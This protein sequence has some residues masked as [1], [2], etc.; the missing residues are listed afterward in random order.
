MEKS[1]L[2]VSELT[3]GIKR[4]LEQ[5]YASV[6]V[7]GEV[8]RLTRHGS[9][10]I[11][12]TI[13]DANAA[14]SAVIWRS[15]AARLKTLPEEGREFVFSG[16]ISVY[17]P[18]GAYQLIVR[19]VAG[20]GAG[21]LAAEFERRKALFAERGWFDTARKKQP[22]P[23][24][25]HI[26]IVTSPSAAALEDVKKV[27][28]TRPGWLELTLS[29]CI[30]QGAQAAAAI[31]TAINRLS[32]LPEPPDVILLVRGGGSMEDLW[33]FNDETVVKAVVDCPVPIIS[34]IGHEIDITLADFAADVR[35][36]TP[37]N[38]A[39]LACPSRDDLRRRLPRLPLLQSLLGHHL[40][41]AQ[42]QYAARYQQL[43]YIWRQEQDR[44]HLHAERA[45]TKLHDALQMQLQQ[46]RRGLQRLTQQLGRLE[47]HARLRRQQRLLTQARRRLQSALPVHIAAAENPVIRLRQRL[48][49]WPHAALTDKRRQWQNR[50]HALAAMDP[51]HVLRR[52]YTLA[53]RID[54]SLLTSATGI[55]TGDE[56]Q[57]HF[58]DGCV[59]TRVTDTHAGGKETA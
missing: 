47:P 44:R 30:V 58:H 19:S 37:S 16:H 26:G 36:A 54:G 40:Q 38:A 51:R 35:A 11:Y 15:T 43:I 52:G 34:G 25:R 1:P 22:P 18:R 39:E 21:R 2:S 20:A 42:K 9:G 50:L 27:L 59:D 7:I 53:L 23:L 31:A 56:M 8:S 32:S 12:F 45:A 48:R 41:H 49:D 4:L 10:H 46:S 17:E 24:P 57:V 14:I 5:N 33:C 55:Q 29:P 6:E 28:A 3:A 13:K